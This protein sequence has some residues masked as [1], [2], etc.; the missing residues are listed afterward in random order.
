MTGTDCPH[1]HGPLPL[2]FD[3]TV[4]YLVFW[5]FTRP[6]RSGILILSCTLIGLPGRLAVCPFRTTKVSRRTQ[7]RPFINIIF[8]QANLRALRCGI[9]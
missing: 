6:V 4:F 7:T 1:G 9:Q 8:Q 2:M 3:V 5:P